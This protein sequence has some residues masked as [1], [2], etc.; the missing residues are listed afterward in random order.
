MFETCWDAVG[1]YTVTATCGSSSKSAEVPVVAMEYIK[2]KCVAN[3]DEN[4]SSSTKIAA[5]G[6]DSAVHRAVVEMKISH[7]SNSPHIRSLNMPV[8]LINA[9][10]RPGNNVQAKLLL[11]GA[12]IVKGDGDGEVPFRRRSGTVTAELVSSN[13]VGTCAIVCGGKAAYVDFGWKTEH[14][15]TGLK[16]FPHDAYHRVSFSMQL[17]GTPVDGHEILLRVIGVH[18]KRYNSER[19]RY[20]DFH[21]QRPESLD[22][23]ARF[24]DPKTGESD[25]IVSDSDVPGTYSS[26]FYGPSDPRGRVLIYRT[27]VEARDHCVHPRVRRVLSVRTESGPGASVG[28]P[29]SR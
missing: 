25:P 4:L 14:K 28:F 11:A 27:D 26:Y 13:L 19:R 18:G 24:V 21:K 23:Y 2:V 15:W 29:R 6:Y 5:G 20:E 12:T 22:A 17:N 3:D 10:G 7:V 16:A 1:T 9:E 8:T